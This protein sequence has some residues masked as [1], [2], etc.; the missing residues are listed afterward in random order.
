MPQLIVR[1]KGRELSRSPITRALFSIGRDPSNDVVI[2]N[3]S[4]SRVH[5]AVAL[6]GGV[7]VIRDKESAN[8]FYVKGERRQAH[9][10]RHG[11]EVLL[12]K[13]AITFDASAGPSA[14]ALMLLADGGDTVVMNKFVDNPDATTHL[15]SRDLHKA[16]EAN[17]AAEDKAR[18][19]ASRE[20]EL[21]RRLVALRHE[22][23]RMK[24]VAA[25]GAGFGVAAI[26]A[27]VVT[28]IAS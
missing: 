23:G 11:D 14:E 12:G 15:N 10:L 19:Q 5:A 13:F 3:P 4:V 25:L 28:I 21:E 17:Q 7:F 6:E 9:V 8:G 18:R 1:L 24:L 22:L 2:D 16:L 27:L 20:R 26:I